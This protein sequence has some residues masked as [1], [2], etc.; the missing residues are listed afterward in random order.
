MRI[1]KFIGLALLS[2][3]VLFLIVSFFLPSKVHFE[4]TAIIKGKPADVF[5]LVNNLK[6]WEMWSPWYRKDPNIKMTYGD[7]LEGVGAFYSWESDKRDVGNG[8]MKIAASNPVDSI[9]TEMN[10]MKEGIAY[11]GFKFVPDGENTKLTWSMDSDAGMNPIKKFFGF[12]LMDQLP[13]NYTKVMTTDGG[14]FNLLFH[15]LLERGVYIAPALYEAGFVSAAHS[16]ADVAATVR[17]AEEV[18]RLL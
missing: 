4:R 18:F 13:Q 8:T 17:A 16:D 6:S 10:F 1:L 14:R 11:T 12:F 7:T 3:V 2:I 9:R 15:G 5:K